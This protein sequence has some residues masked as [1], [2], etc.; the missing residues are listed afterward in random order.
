M[1]GFICNFAT[2]LFISV[3][4]FLFSGDIFSVQAKIIAVDGREE[5]SF[6]FDTL[7]SN[8][9][10]D[11]EKGVQFMRVTETV[12]TDRQDGANQKLPVTVCFD[13]LKFD[14]EYFAFAVYSASIDNTVSKPLLAWIEEYGLKA[15]INASMYLPD[16]KTS[17]GYLK[18]GNKFNNKRRGQKLGAYFVSMPL[19][20]YKGKIPEAA[21][22]YADDPDL[23]RYFLKGEKEHTLAGALKKYNVV[24]QNFRIFD[25]EENSSDWKNKRRHAIAAVGEDKDGRILLMYASNPMTIGE[26][27][28]ILQKNPLLKIKRAMYTEGGSE[29]GMA[30]RNT[31][32][33]LWQYEDNIIFFLKGIIKLPNVI[34]VKK[35]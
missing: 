32:L 8:V 31:S 34:G 19:A 12:M 6:P 33:F 10:Q 17:I 9:W 28:T 2:A 21:I 27:R 15:A 11:L 4:C 1:F 23:S 24:V 3:S 13:I 25:L 14:P 22:I 18:K 30:Y 5:K 35:R 7:K 29:A 16:E 26:F 20:Q